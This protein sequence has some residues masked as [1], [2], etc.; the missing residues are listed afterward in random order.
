MGICCCRNDHT[1]ENNAPLI[2]KQSSKQSY[3]TVTNDQTDIILNT[4]QPQTS[5]CDHK[6]T[7][8]IE[9]NTT[10]CDRFKTAHSGITISNN[11]KT[12]TT[13]RSIPIETFAYHN[14]FGSIP[15]ERKNNNTYEWTLECNK[16][17]ALMF[18][19]IASTIDRN[20][21][22]DKIDYAYDGFY[23]KTYSLCK[24]ENY[25]MQWDSGDTIKMRVDFEAKEILL[26]VNDKEQ[27]APLTMPSYLMSCYYLA[28]SMPVGLAGESI[29][30]KNGPLKMEKETVIKQAVPK[31]MLLFIDGYLREQCHSEEK[32]NCNMD[33]STIS[34]L[35]L[36]YYLVEDDI[37]DP[38]AVPSGLTIKGKSIIHRLVFAFYTAYL[39]NVVYERVHVWTIKVN[40]LYE[41]AAWTAFGIWKT[42]SGEPQTNGSF[43][44][45]GGIGYAFLLNNGTKIDPNKAHD[46]FGG[47]YGVK[48]KSGDIIKMILNFKTLS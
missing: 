23:G 41:H 27:N 7:I 3:Q 25:G 35:I 47:N 30:I 1:S 32:Y 5:C 24:E 11:G 43:P 34:R 16:R 39:T 46:P 36:I 33:I 37:W 17:S 48:C 12:V 31:D 29:T 42:K 8:N 9:S 2:T 14:A 20:A 45:K 15:I 28:V 18:I 44:Q 4:N 21:T 13:N 22:Y 38:K 40:K 6:E 10:R 26:K 19:G